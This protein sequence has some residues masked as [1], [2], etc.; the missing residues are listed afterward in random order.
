MLDMDLQKDLNLCL[1]EDDRSLHE[2]Y[3][4][5]LFK[6]LNNLTAVIQNCNKYNKI[7]VF[8]SV[9]NSYLDIDPAIF[10]YFRE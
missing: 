7:I 6:R 10:M 1:Y 5:L 2:G 3:C 8:Y 9:Q 4:N